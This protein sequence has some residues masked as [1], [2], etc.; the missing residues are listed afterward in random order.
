MKTYLVISLFFVAF[1]SSINAQN[2]ILLEADYTNSSRTRENIK[3]PL[4]VFNRISPI[5]GFR[6]P[7]QLDEA[8]LCLVRPLGGVAVNG[9]PDLE[10]DTYRWDGRNFVTN[11]APLKQQIDNVMRSGLGIYQIVLDNPSWDFQR[12]ANGNLPGGTYLGETYG[13]AEPPTDFN[14]WAQYLRQ[15][16]SFLIETYGREKLRDIQF[17]IGREIG[18]RGHWTG[19]QQQF[20]RFYRRSVEAV[21]S[22]FP[23]AIIGSHFLWGSANNSW[24]P[25][26]VRWCKVNN[27]PYD[28]VG[29]SYYPPYDRADRTN[30]K[31]VY[32]KDFSVIKDIPE[33]NEEAKFEIH[34]FALT[35]TFGGNT[36]V[37]AP[38]EHQNSFLV[39]WMKQFFENDIENLFQWGTGEQYSPANAEIL[40]LRGYTYH[41]NS[42]SGEQ[43]SNENYVDAIFTSN[44]SSNELS[45]MAYNYNANPNSN[46]SEDLRLVADVNAPGGT[47]YRYRS[48]VLNKADGSFEYSD[49]INARTT[50]G[51]GNKSQISFNR[52]LPV[53]SFLKYEIE[54]NQT[55]IA[56]QAPSVSFS[57]PANNATFEVGQEVTLTASASDPDS[58]LDRVNF[59]I[60]GD[61]FKSVNQRPFTNS[62]T[63][64]ETGTYRIT[65]RAIDKEGLTTDALVTITVNNPTPP[66]REPEV[67]FSSPANNGTFEVGQE[68]TLSASATDPDS[69]L[70][71]VNFLING[72]FFKS[73][74]QRP[75]TN[76]FTPTEPGTYRITARAI[77]KEGL[78][79]DTQVTITV[80]N[81][82][83]PNREPEVSFSSPANNDTFEVGQEITLTASAMDPDSNLDR[84]NFLINDEFF[85]SV[86]QRPFTNSFTPTEP[87]TY[88]IIARAIDREGL[89]TDTQISITVNNPAPVNQQ[90]SASITSPEDGSLFTFGTA[91]DLIAFA[92]D[93]DGNLDRVN[94]IINDNFYRTDNVRPFVDSFTP[95][96]PGTYKIAVRA[97]DKEG[98]SFESSVTI[99]VEATLSS[100]NFLKPDDIQK[101]KLY[102]TPAINKLNIVGLTK[103]VTPVAIIDITGKT[104]LNTEISINDPQ[105]PVYQLSNGVYFLKISNN[106]NQKTISFIK[107]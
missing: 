8:R 18:T 23:E 49:W 11:F 43:K 74:N 67:S 50:N 21:R 4:N 91:I 94:F 106:P 47:N 16:M 82:T 3:Y 107:N 64:T 28:F 84:V 81:P 19:T 76:S 69:N 87:G 41:L 104:V 37:E 32:K 12:D 98:L 38:V 100:E 86:N 57:A 51:S 92:T 73:V 13:N 99:T 34:E 105:I 96:E 44:P 101:I 78:T 45:I 55:T 59:L 10:R 2:R 93:P 53:F 79:A 88:R 71:R 42:I 6:R 5:R 1:W 25:D 31:E 30:F 33:W 72:E 75:F 65:A 77:D 103:N 97:F 61:F 29:A 54:L 40:K 83:P 102:P 95:E 63:P 27:V 17:G 70:D 22:V 7:Q 14:A 36:F 15:V 26:F 66:N 62:F 20:F 46:V 80:N 39:G 48:A 85:K 35:S 60:N 24:G 56:N 58:N 9:E 52:T 68:I 89:T 90:P